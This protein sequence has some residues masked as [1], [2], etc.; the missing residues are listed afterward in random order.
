MSYWWPRNAGEFFFGCGLRSFVKGQ[1][2]GVLAPRSRSFFFLVGTLFIFSENFWYWYVPNEECIKNQSAV[3]N[4]SECQFLPNWE[5]VTV[6]FSVRIG[7][8]KKKCFKISQCWLEIR[9]FFSS[10]T[11]HLQPNTPHCSPFSS[12]PIRQSIEQR[13]MKICNFVI[14][15]SCNWTLGPWPSRVVQRPRWGVNSPPP[16]VLQYETNYETIAQIFAEK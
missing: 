16:W 9:V 5:V 13:N 2:Y 4:K 15:K 6:Q 1:R 14:Q 12:I 8:N 7:K 11:G 3:W 10:R